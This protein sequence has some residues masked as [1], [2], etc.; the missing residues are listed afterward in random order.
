MP[1]LTDPRSWGMAS[2]SQFDP[3]LMNSVGRATLAMLALARAIR[4]LERKH[5]DIVARMRQ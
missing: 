3:W 1:N 4:E 2:G 5:P